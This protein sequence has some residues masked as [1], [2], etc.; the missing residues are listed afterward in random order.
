[1]GEGLS[2]DD[3]VDKVRKLRIIASAYGSVPQLQQRRTK[4][5]TTVGDQDKKYKVLVL[6]LFGL[7]QIVLLPA[8]SR[9]SEVW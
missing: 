5:E 3:G 6:L 4:S 8:V 1:M 7:E 9:A 2:K